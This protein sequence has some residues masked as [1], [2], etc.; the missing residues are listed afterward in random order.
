VRCIV[1]GSHFNIGSVSHRGAIQDGSSMV[2][3]CSLTSHVRA[4]QLMY[5]RCN[6]ASSVNSI[7]RRILG[8]GIDSSDRNIYSLCR[9]TGERRPREMQIF[10]K[11]AIT[12]F[13]DGISGPPCC[14]RQHNGDKLLMDY[15]RP[16]TG[17]IPPLLRHKHTRFLNGDKEWVRLCQFVL[18]CS[19]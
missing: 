18:F 1:S 17:T 15:P 19:S 16:S 9:V 8:G 11:P 10:A 14:D 6:V 3:G 13:Q 2:R 4:I 7:F 12:M 5:R